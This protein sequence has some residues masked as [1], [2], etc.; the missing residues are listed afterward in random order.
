[1]TEGSDFE[2]LTPESLGLWTGGTHTKE[3]R[4]K[5]FWRVEV[6]EKGV[7]KFYRDTLF[8]PIATGWAEGERK[9]LREEKRFEV[10]VKI[11][12]HNQPQEQAHG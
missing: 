8:R 12:P 9:Q 10:F 1:V 7:R 11:V 6:W 4:G 2:K 5:P 3:H